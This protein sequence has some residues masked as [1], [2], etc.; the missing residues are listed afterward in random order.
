MKSRN[1]QSKRLSLHNHRFKCIENTSNKKRQKSAIFFDRDGVLIDDVHY[2]SNPL[3]VKIL[4]G[5]RDLLR[6]SNKAGWLNIVLTNQSGISKGILDWDD[7]E[8]ITHQMLNL[9][10]DECYID[11]IYANSTPSSEVFLKNSWRKPSP[12]MIF[13]AVK[14]FNINLNNSFLIGDRLTDLLSAK[15]AGLKNFIHVLTGHGEEERVNILND[16]RESYE[17][18]EL[19]FMKNLSDFKALNRKNNNFI[20]FPFRN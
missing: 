2:I 4:S 7:Y 3:D 6:I 11:A 12:N 17:K 5:V 10:G 1:Y 14:D 19:I 13:E 15:N 16:F 8:K 9:L 20:K 18:N